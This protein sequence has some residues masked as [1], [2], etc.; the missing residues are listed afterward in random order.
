MTEDGAI[1][2]A[3]R[4]T[5]EEFVGYLKILAPNPENINVLLDSGVDLFQLAQY[6]AVH[7]FVV[8]SSES[9][10]TRVLRVQLVFIGKNGRFNLS[11]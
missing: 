7:C 8:A 2:C 11:S 9:E 10:A 6:V 4:M 3:R 1:D 5:E